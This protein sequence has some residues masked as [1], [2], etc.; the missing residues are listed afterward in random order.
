M[1]GRGA[2]AW[3]RRH[4]GLHRSVEGSSRG[5]TPQEAASASRRLTLRSAQTLRREGDDVGRVGRRDEA[6]SGHDQTGA[7]ARRKVAG[8][9][10]VR[11]DHDRQIPLQELLL[12]DGEVHLPV[13]DGRQHFG[14]EV[15]GGEMDRLARGGDRGQ[16]RACHGRA[17]G[18]EAVDGRI[19]LERRRHLGLHV[20]RVG[21]LA[22]QDRA[23]GRIE[24]HPGEEAVAA[25]GQ[26]LVADLLVEADGVLDAGGQEPLAG[27]QAGLELRL[28]DMRLDA[29]LTED[30]RPGVH[31]DHRDPGC[32]RLLDRRAKGVGVRDRDDEAA[33]LLRHGGVD[34]RGHAGHV[35]L[36]RRRVVGDRD[37]HVGCAGRDAIADHAP[38]PVDGLAVGHDLDLDVAALDQRAVETGPTSRGR[39]AGAGRGVARRQDDDR[40]REQG[41]GLSKLHPVCLLTCRS[42]TLA[43]PRERRGCRDHSPS[44]PPDRSVGLGIPRPGARPRHLLSSPAIAAGSSACDLLESHRTVL[45]E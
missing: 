29:D 32:D 23:G 27:A 13:L 38:E 19:G 16:R 36:L 12:V 20:G 37:A 1:R 7:V 14:A 42:R 31:R 10:V 41:G 40:T 24:T 39:A 18:Q 17:E 25:Q 26:G 15:E 33:R 9:R 28:T 35:A 45:V 8:L 43:R 2:G 4:R 5:P 34:E 6:R 30:V 44:D 3:G 21:D 22:G 11:E